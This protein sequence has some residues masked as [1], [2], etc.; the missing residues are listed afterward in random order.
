MAPENRFRRSAL[1]DVLVH[2][3]A[4]L[5]SATLVVSI[6]GV[7]EGGFTAVLQIGLF[8]SVWHMSGRRLLPVFVRGEPSELARWLFAL[9]VLKLSEPFGFGFAAFLSVVIWIDIQQSIIRILVRLTTGIAP[10][11]GVPHPVDN[12]SRRN[13]DDER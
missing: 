5:T 8:T 7:D 2:L 6:I 10:W 12:N 3:I 11:S 9:L 4:G 1:L 13:N